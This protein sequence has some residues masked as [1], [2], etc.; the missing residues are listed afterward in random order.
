MGVTSLLYYF[1]L[2]TILF[3]LTM[4]R[5]P[6]ADLTCYSHG[7]MGACVVCSWPRTPTRQGACIHLYTIYI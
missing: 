4:D 7:T 2:S 1:T 3:F 5:Y 6:F